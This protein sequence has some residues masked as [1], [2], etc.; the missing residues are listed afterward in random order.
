MRRCQTR[1]FLKAFKL[2][3]SLQPEAEFSKGHKPLEGFQGHKHAFWWCLSAKAR[4]DRQ[5]AASVCTPSFGGLAAR[6]GVS[7]GF[8]APSPQPW[9]G[10]AVPNAVPTEARLE[11]RFGRATSVSPTDRVEFHFGAALKAEV[12]GVLSTG[13]KSPFSP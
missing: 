1:G 12:S 13:L 10:T 11:A 7:D 3:R 9:L 2:E 8:K 5:R 4:W 6:T